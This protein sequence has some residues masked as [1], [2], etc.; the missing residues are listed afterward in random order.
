M[1]INKTKLENFNCQ[2]EIILIK[3]RVFRI[4]VKAQLDSS[5]DQSE[6]VLHCNVM[7]FQREKVCENAPFGF[8]FVHCF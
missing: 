3:D 1:F 5:F 8:W 2:I 6:F 7:E 4:K